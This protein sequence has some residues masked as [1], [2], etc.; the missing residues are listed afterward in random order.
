MAKSTLYT[1]TVRK[2]TKAYNERIRYYEKK[3]YGATPERMAM[4]SK[5]EK[6]TKRQMETYIKNLEGYNKE[7]AH[8]T[9]FGV[10]QYELNQHKKA[11][12]RYNASVT[13]SQKMGI[14][15]TNEQDREIN[16]H[17]TEK[18]LTRQMKKP[19]ADRVAQFRKKTKELQ[20]MPTV[21]LMLEKKLGQYKLNYLSSLQNGLGIGPGN[22]TYDK[23][24]AM[25]ITTFSRTIY[26]NASL[27]I[28]ENYF[29]GLDASGVSENAQ[30]NELN[31]KLGLQ[32]V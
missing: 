22:P 14:K 27:V 20:A 25:D 21:E 12:A 8:K 17:N 9:S 7:T 13:K 31:R 5:S 16:K 15:E 11:A 29:S 18:Y 28:K 19:E 24:Q 3:G 30:L 6:F 32:E 2:A 23:I 10:T 26:N 4:P 1:D